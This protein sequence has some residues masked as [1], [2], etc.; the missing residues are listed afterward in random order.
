MQ[1]LGEDIRKEQVRRQEKIDAE[2]RANSEKADA[3]ARRLAEKQLE[4]EKQ[5]MSDVRAAHEAAVRE[6]SR[7]DTPPTKDQIDTRMD[8]ILASWRRAYKNIGNTNVGPNERN[9]GQKQPEVIWSKPVSALPPQAL[10]IAHQ[11][12]QSVA[13]SGGTQE[14]AMARIEEALGV[15]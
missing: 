8:E 15:A 12:A 6:L 2:N 11:I 14:E 10:D 7:G 1:D 9:P 5:K 13:A 3:E 4:Q